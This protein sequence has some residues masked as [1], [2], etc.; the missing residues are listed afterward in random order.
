MQDLKRIKQQ[1][2][3]AKDLFVKKDIRRANLDGDV[4]ETTYEFVPADVLGDVRY[5]PEPNWAR[6]PQMSYMEFYK[7]RQAH[8]RLR[9]PP[10]DFQVWWCL[11]NPAFATIE[12]PCRFSQGLRERNWTAHKHYRPDAEPWSVSFF[13]DSGRFLR[14]AFPGEPF[15]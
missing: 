1:G 15:S 4:V 13:R 7:V 14:P 11:C 3:S 10:S 8:E 6:V 5:A 9:M 12:K 2:P